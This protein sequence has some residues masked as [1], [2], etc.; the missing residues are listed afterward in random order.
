MKGLIRFTFY[1]KF[2]GDRRKTKQEKYWVTWFDTKCK[3]FKSLTWKCSIRS[4][5]MQD[6][7]VLLLGYYYLWYAGCGLNHSF[8]SQWIEQCRLCW[9]LVLTPSLDTKLSLPLN[10][11]FTIWFVSKKS[12]IFEQ[13]LRTKK[14]K[15]FKCKKNPHTRFRTIQS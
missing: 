2:I 11:Y 12:L 15:N 9:S 5:S 3:S 8:H 7:R 13:F 4:S 1:I 6:I 14:Q 10:I